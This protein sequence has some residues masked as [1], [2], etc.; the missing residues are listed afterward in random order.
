MK[1]PDMTRNL[2]RSLFT[3]EMAARNVAAAV[4]AA[5]VAA[6]A[7]VVLVSATLSTALIVGCDDVGASTVGGRCMRGSARWMKKKSLSHCPCGSRVKPVD[8]M[9][10]WGY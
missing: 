4:S 2:G 10:W 1:L 3:L 9:D 7:M 8:G 5:V 6:A